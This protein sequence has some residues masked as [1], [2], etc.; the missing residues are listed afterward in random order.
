MPEIT[1]HGEIGVHQPRNGYLNGVRAQEDIVRGE[2]RKK[3]QRNI[4]DAARA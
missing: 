2:K 4:S 1:E 3:P